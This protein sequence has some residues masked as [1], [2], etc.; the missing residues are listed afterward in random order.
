[1]LIVCHKFY[2]I[3][4]DFELHSVPVAVNSAR[5]HWSTICMPRHKQTRVSDGRL[6]AVRQMEEFLV[7]FNLNWVGLG[8]V[9]GVTPATLSQWKSGRCHPAETVVNFLYVLERS[10][11]ARELAGVN[12]W[13]LK[14]R[15]SDK[16]KSSTKPPAAKNA[17]DQAEVCVTSAAPSEQGKEGQIQPV[18]SD[19]ELAS[20]RFDIERFLEGSMD[21]WHTR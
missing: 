15:R 3:G 13:R 17:G 9:L 8:L 4:K 21:M 20:D 12:R 1:M 18:V 16:P 2:A 10:A 5:N 14:R 6:N 19:S 11:E 7:K